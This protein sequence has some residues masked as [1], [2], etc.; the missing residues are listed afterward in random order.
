M[1]TQKGAAAVVKWPATRLTNW[2]T[3][4]P[5]KARASHPPVPQTPPL[6]A[7]CAEC[8]T[9]GSS[10]H[11][12]DDDWYCW[13]STFSLWSPP[14]R[15]R[16]PPVLVRWMILHWWRCAR[17]L[18]REGPGR[19]RRGRGEKK[20]KKNIT[21]RLKHRRQQLIGGCYKSKASFSVFAVAVMQLTPLWLVKLRVD[22]VLR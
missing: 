19:G 7:A 20:E 17:A 16:S 4:L 12:F 8:R 13:V 10:V 6:P 14:S 11:T 5:A 15:D 1:K 21:P 9:G 3:L 22:F 18:A 2:H